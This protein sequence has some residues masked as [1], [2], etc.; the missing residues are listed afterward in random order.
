MSN[1][2]RTALLVIDVQQDFCEGGALP[3]VGGNA[4]AEHVADYIRARRD[5]V[6]LVISTRDWHQGD[7]DNDGHFAAPG[8]QPDY[9]TTWP[10]H[11]VQRTPGA[12]YAPAI[13][14]VADLID[15]DILIGQ[16]EPGYSG[17]SG[18]DEDGRTLEQLLTEAQITDVEFVGLA[19]DHCVLASALD[20][21]RLGYRA[22]VLLDLCEGVSESETLAAINQ[23][24][25]AGVS[26]RYA[27]PHPR[28]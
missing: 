9:R 12:Q 4:V 17:F 18:A 8:T 5:N 7:N 20:A 27:H 1:T 16:G 23:L 3:I 6:Q 11:C 2:T 28:H 25:D 19:T 22:D 26:V 13:A 21:T 24:L 15:A 10:V 14:D